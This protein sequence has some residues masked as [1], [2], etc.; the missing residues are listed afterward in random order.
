[1]TDSNIN[2]TELLGLLAEDDNRAYQ[3]LYSLYY[4]ALKSLAV[5]YVKDKDLA[6]DMV[7]DAFF[8]LLQSQRKFGS[9]DEVKYFLYASLKNRC[10]SQLRRMQVRD[11]AEPVIRELYC[12]LDDYWNRAME[13]DVY[14]RLMAAAETLSPQ[15]R[16]VMQLTLEGLKVAEIAERLN[17]SPETVKEHRANGKKK[18]GAWMRN[19]EMLALLYFILS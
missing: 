11:K 1:M 18:I 19:N 5:Y 9:M 14:A 13:E 2:N 7:Q 16:L 8:S 17:I 4:V 6:G 3:R 10:I 15:S 12:N